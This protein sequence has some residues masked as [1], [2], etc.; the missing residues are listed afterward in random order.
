MARAALPWPGGPV[1]YHWVGCYARPTPLVS[2]PW[3]RLDA[4]GVRDARGTAAAL[5]PTGVHFA[6]RCLWLRIAWGLLQWLLKNFSN[7]SYSSPLHVGCS[8]RPHL[9]KDLPHLCI[10]CSAAAQQVTG[11]LLCSLRASGLSYL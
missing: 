2:H 9:V 11:R 10:K 6:T 3:A 5:C 4:V 8:L 1:A 7:A